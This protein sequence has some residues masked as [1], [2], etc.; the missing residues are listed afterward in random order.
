[1]LKRTTLPAVTVPLERATVAFTVAV[2]FV[3]G[4]R[5][6]TLV[7]AAAVTAEEAAEA[8]ATLVAE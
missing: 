4:V 6:T 5:T 7:A 1:M 8:I 3:T 2:P